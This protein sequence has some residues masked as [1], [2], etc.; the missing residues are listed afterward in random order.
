MLSVHDL[1]RRLPVVDPRLA[2]AAV[3]VVLLVVMVLTVATKSPQ[4]G[5]RGGDAL[6]Y[7]LCVGLAA[8]YA[9]H[10]RSPMP[11]LAVEMVSLLAFAARHYAAF[12]GLNVW[13]LLFGI[14]L[15]CGRRPALVAL[16]VSFAAFC[17]A[18]AA[19]PPGVAT[20]ATWSSTLLATAVAWLMGENQR[21]RRARWAALEER[22]R[23]LE[24]EREEK[25]A[26]AVAEERLRIARELHDVVAPSMSV[27][28]V[29]S[30]VGHHVI[31]TH[32]EQA[33]AALAAIEMTSR[34]ALAEMR[35]LLGVL[36]PDGE[37]NGALTPAPGLSDLPV[38]VKQV[39]AGGVRAQVRVDGEPHELGPGVDLSAYRIVQEA[40]TN[41]I[42]HGGSS[43][44]V[45]LGYGP[46]ELL[47][48]VT[49]RPDPGLARARLP[50]DRDRPAQPG[51]RSAAGHGLIG[52]RE[53][54]AVY[55]GEFEAG[56]VPGGGFRVTARLPYGGDRR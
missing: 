33:R 19:Q 18:L 34:S 3:A 44:D 51:P 29:Q 26:H 46:D 45:L 1:R 48:Q 42:K 38:L 8:P 30:G 16:G 20:P 12:P 40:L 24:R 31:D 15:H 4:P 2:D 25:A 27:I 50:V 56:P 5:Q 35:R 11:A 13:V 10:R 21:N 22:S 17:V 41:V 49:D 43:A 6:A 52:M 7:L 55:A 28:A 9:F 47:V 23:R 39:C 36:R 14:A 54:V 37:S 32:P 53:R